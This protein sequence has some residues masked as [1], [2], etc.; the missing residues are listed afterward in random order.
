MN[1]LVTGGAGF[2]GSNLVKQLLE[3]G[4]DIWSLDDLSTGRTTYL[5]DVL[6]H[7][8]HTFVNGSVLDRGTLAILMD[9][10][11]VIFHLAA[12]LGVK[13]TVDNPIKVIEGNIDGTRNILELA[14]SRGLKVIF[15]STSEIYG[16][17]ENLPFHEASDR[18]YGTSS[19]HRWCYATAKSLDEHL[20]FGYAQKG[21][22]VTVLRYF[23]AYGPGQTNTQ[24]G[25]VVPRFI[26]A[27]LA[28]RPLE[29][30][31]DGTQSRCFTYIDDTVK[32]TIAAIT[33]SANGLA[34]NIGS[35]HRITIMELA[36]KIIALTGSKSKVVL[37]SYNDAYG[38]G[39]ED[40]HARIPDLTRARNVLGYEPG[41]TL[42]E[43]LM[44]TIAWYQAEAEAGAAAAAKTFT[45]SGEGR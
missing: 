14:Y 18:V 5:K 38:P 3:A 32:G 24:Y 44:R 35:S 25:M 7:K 16:K 43:G 28:D 37:K 41:V 39:Y 9:H 17:N 11:D 40:M 1:I 26:Q 4:H 15:A 31:G 23:N 34:V 30:H 13:N 45:D 12:V 21:L 42:D 2:I 6:Q 19:I 8:H 33:P 27:A 22:P 36:Q 10:V 20:C 29:V